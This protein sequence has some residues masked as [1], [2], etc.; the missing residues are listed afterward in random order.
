MESTLKW[1]SPKSSSGSILTAIIAHGVIYGASALILGQQLAKTLPLQGEVEL[2]YEVLN[3]PPSEPV[4][5]VK[6]VRAA[7]PEMPVVSKTK[8]DSQPHEMQDAQSDVIGTQQAAPVQAAA[9]G[10]DS[11]GTAEATPFYRIKP[12]YPRAALVEGSEGWVMMKID[13]DEAGE[14]ENVR[15]VD[16]VKRNL[17]QDEAR[18]AVEKWK[19]KPFLDLGG[20]PIRK[21]DHLVRVEFKLSEA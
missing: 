9:V 10:S 8:V 16:G 21:A 11:N 6:R 15:V 5:E 7:E 1:Y 13:I 20:K 2:G 12:K 19:Y 17:F 14:V 4:K 3:E 18:R